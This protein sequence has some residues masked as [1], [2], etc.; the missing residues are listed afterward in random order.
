ME[1]PV[2]PLPALDSGAIAGCV[3]YVA[4]ATHLLLYSAWLLGC[5][6]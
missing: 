1:I 2:N 4:L 6:M 5:P 3:C